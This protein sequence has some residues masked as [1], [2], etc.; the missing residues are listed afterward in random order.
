MELDVVYPVARTVMAVESGRVPIGLESPLIDLGRS[1]P[2]T[3]FRHQVDSPTA[4]VALEFVDKGRFRCG[5]VVLIERGRLIQDLVGGDRHS[6]ISDEATQGQRMSRR[7]V[8]SGSVE[9]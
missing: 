3:E 7:E 4:A 5:Q 6:L 9:R 2:S 1:D 8:A